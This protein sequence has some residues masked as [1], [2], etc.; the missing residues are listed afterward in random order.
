MQSA[1]PPC[2]SMSASTNASSARLS[3]R[4]VSWRRRWPEP[5]ADVCPVSV[6]VCCLEGL[7]DNGPQNLGVA[8]LSL[9]P[10]G[11]VAR[12][13][14][15]KQT[16]QPVRLLRI[17]SL[18]D[19]RLGAVLRSPSPWG[20]SSYGPPRSPCR[21]V[22]GVLLTVAPSRPKD[23]LHLASGHQSPL[24]RRYSSRGSRCVAISPF[25]PSR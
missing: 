25:R 4:H 2:R 3:S 10:C 22:Q 1:D 15:A 11:H 23:I 24:S 17:L 13:C 16:H 20:A 7:F 14:P 12:D 21:T 5:R 9:R 6:A 8:A 19:G 18:C